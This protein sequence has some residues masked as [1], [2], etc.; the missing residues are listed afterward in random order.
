MIIKT[1]TVGNLACNNYL[2]VCESTRQAVIIDAGGEVDVVMRE[3]KAA[4]AELKYILHTHGHF[5]HVAGNY[6]LRKQTGAKALIHKDD[7]P[8]IGMFKQHLMMFG[9]PDAENPVIDEHVEDEQV[10]NVGEMSFKVIHTPGHSA[11]GVCY[12]VDN[13]LFSGDT[14]FAGSIG[15]TDLPGGS[16]EKIGESIVN[17]LFALNDYVKIYPGHGPST[18]IGYEKQNNP[19][20]GEKARNRQW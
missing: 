14:L 19:Y 11:G 5:D 3:I 4:N 15:R 17:K 12:L 6:L 9:E 16:F 10:I 13:V 1:L 20:L 8:L 2:V 7:M 18:T